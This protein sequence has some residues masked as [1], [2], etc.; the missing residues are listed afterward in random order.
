MG[1]IS[2]RPEDDPQHQ[3]KSNNLTDEDKAF[4][5]AKVNEEPKAATLHQ[6]V[7]NDHNK[8]EVARTS[9]PQK[10]NNEP[11]KVEPARLSRKEL[12]K[13]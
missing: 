13:R 8:A 5:K 6:E 12:L 10:T 2:K 9:I 3:R 7:S 4:Q 11:V 1:C